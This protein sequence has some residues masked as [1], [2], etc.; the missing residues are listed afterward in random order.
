M[1]VIIDE[2]VAFMVPVVGCCINASDDFV[3]EL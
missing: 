2:G 1:V 3:F